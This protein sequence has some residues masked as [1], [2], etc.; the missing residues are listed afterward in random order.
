M[1][2]SIL[3]HGAPTLQ[4]HPMRVQSHP[5]RCIGY[6]VALIIWVNLNVTAFYVNMT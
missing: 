4:S 6:A 3:I 1:F 5:R 2:F